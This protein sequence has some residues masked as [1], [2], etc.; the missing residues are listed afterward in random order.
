MIIPLFQPGMT[1]PHT[2]PIDCTGIHFQRA[3]VVK[4]RDAI[5]QY[6]QGLRLSA[7][8]TQTARNQALAHL[9]NGGSVQVAI[10]IG[11]S[12]AD[13]LFVAHGGGA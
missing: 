5:N 12:R 8:D 7:N 6:C 11:K 10:D 3:R 4:V 1:A 13:A 2:G 9:M